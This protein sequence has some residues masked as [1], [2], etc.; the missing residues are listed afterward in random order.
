MAKHGMDWHFRWK[1]IASIHDVV[2]VKRAGP[3][4]QLPGWSIE[5]GG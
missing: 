4:S 1:P 3:A 2:E 5:Y